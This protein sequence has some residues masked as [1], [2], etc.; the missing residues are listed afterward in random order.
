VIAK[1]EWHPGEL[2]PR[3]GFIVTNI[4]PRRQHRRFL[5]QARQVRAMDQRGKGRDSMDA[6]VMPLLRGQR[7][8]PSAL[9][10]GLQSVQVM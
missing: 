8:S 9:R 7:R 3:V 4:S 1:V 5:Q 2:D 6:A 10:V